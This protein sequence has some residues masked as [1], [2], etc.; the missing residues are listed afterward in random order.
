MAEWLTSGKKNSPSYHLER[1]EEGQAIYKAV[2]SLALR[3]RVV[4]VLHYFN[5]LSLQEIAEILDIPVG[6]VKS[7]LHYGRRALRM[8]L[9][10]QDGTKLGE[11]RYEFT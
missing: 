6:T 3:H 5:D 7:R 9:E 8:F 4:I 11:V 10:A 2:A 1:N